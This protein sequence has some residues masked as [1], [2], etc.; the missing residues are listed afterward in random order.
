MKI[1]TGNGASVRYTNRIRE[2]PVPGTAEHSQTRP[3]EPTVWRELLNLGIKLAAIAIVF[4]LIFT[5]F[6]GFHRSA[7]PDMAPLV[8]DGDLVMFYRLDKNYSIGDLLLLEYQGECQIRRVVA[9][10][11]DT[12]DITED[13]LIVNGAIQ[14]ELEIYQQTMRYE[15]EMSFPLTV[16]EGQVFVLGDARENANDSRVYGPVTVKDTLGKVITVIRRRN[17]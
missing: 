4:M 9:K 16:E 10:A 17:L 8:K 13:G 15:N 12:V 6:Y 3:K 14:D 11:G 2:D 7:D 1:N 5:F